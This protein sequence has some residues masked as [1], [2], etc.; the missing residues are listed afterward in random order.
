MPKTIYVAPGVADAV[1]CPVCYVEQERIAS[2]TTSRPA[3][4]LE[5]SAGDRTFCGSCGVWLIFEGRPV[6]SLRVATSAEIA[7]VP[8]AILEAVSRY[9]LRRP[10]RRI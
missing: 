7:Q 1:V 9:P 10:P 5:P 4:P 8:A 3:A 2:L 6:R